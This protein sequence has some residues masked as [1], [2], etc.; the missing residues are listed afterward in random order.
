MIQGVQHQPLAA[1]RFPA[2]CRGNGFS[3][4]QTDIPAWTEFRAGLSG[5][6]TQEGFQ[7]SGAESRSNVF[8]CQPAGKGDFHDAPHDR[9]FRILSP[10]TGSNVPGPHPDD[11]A[12]FR[13]DGELADI[14]IKKMFQGSVQDGPDRAIRFVQGNMAFLHGAEEGE[15][16]LAAGLQFARNEAAETVAFRFGAGLHQFVMQQ[17]L[18]DAVLALQLTQ[19]VPEG[20]ALQVFFFFRGLH[21]AGDDPDLVQRTLVQPLFAL[22]QD[23]LYVGLQ[24]LPVFPAH[25]SVP[26]RIIICS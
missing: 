17:P 2:D 12:V 5:F 24:H 10:Q 11:N 13:P 22:G 18:V 6:H 3:G 20:I 4:R 23:G 19:G 21:T 16:H 7:G 25:G 15:V 14:L 26:L 8:G 1:F 9:R